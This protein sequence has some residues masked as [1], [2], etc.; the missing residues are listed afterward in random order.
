MATPN[1]KLYDGVEPDDEWKTQ[2]K[3]RIEGELQ[4]IVKDAKVSMDNKLRHAP[5]GPIERQRF[6]EEH[7]LAMCNIRKL[8]VESFQIALEHE[9]QERRWAVGQQVHSAWSEALLQE[10][11]GILDRTQ[12]GGSQNETSRSRATTVDYL[13]MHTVGTAPKSMQY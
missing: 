9:R 2:L 11:Q 13:I 12:Q 6:A 7:S 3:V 4:A 10:Q 8:A 5:L 1:F